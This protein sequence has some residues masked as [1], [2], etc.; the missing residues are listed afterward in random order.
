MPYDDILE[1]MIKQFLR[2]S[3]KIAQALI[4]QRVN[5]WC[6]NGSNIDISYLIRNYTAGAHKLDERISQLLQ[7]F[8]RRAE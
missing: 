5:H 1:I 4:P 6:G 2:I 8:P 7:L 3:L